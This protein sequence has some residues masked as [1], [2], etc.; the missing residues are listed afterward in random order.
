MRGAAWERG[1]GIGENYLRRAQRRPAI[2]DVDDSGASCGLRSGRGRH[3][4]ARVCYPRRSVG[5]ARSLV[6]VHCSARE[7][8]YLGVARAGAN[9]NHGDGR[10]LARVFRTQTIDC[11]GSARQLGHMQMVVAIVSH[12]ACLLCEFSSM[13][14]RSKVGIVM[15]RTNPP[16]FVMGDAGVWVWVDILLPIPNPY[17]SCGFCGFRLVWTRAHPR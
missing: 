13:L 9:D 10:Q 11:L 5:P 1:G 17:P 16:G 15:G 4:G 7:A 2:A 3:Y 6:P 12:R 8:G 14:Q